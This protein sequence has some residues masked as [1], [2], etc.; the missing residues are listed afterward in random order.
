MSLGRTGGSANTLGV[1]G[2]VGGRQ[3]NVRGEEE[4]PRI[5]HEMLCRGERT[6]QVYTWKGGEKGPPCTIGKYVQGKG[7]N[8]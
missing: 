6:A 7:Q 2:K 8:L 3:G 5:C 4:L 1:L